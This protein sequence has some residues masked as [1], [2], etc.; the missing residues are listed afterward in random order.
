[1]TKHGITGGTGLN[2]LI[3]GR[4]RFSSPEFFTMDFSIKTA[5]YLSYF[6]FRIEEQIR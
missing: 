5:T 3:A 4:A 1:M 6:C 2:W